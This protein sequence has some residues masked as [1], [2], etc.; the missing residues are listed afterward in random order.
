MGFASSLLPFAFLLLIFIIFVI[1][2]FF[3]RKRK[4]EYYRDKERPYKS[5]P[6]EDALSGR[7][8]ELL[9][10]FQT[11]SK[12]L[13]AQTE[14]RIRILNAL[15]AEADSK[16]QQMRGII[17]NEDTDRPPGDERPF[18]ESAP[19][20]RPVSPPK[21]K[22][23]PLTSTARE[24]LRRQFSEL[25][26]VYRDIYALADSGMTAIEIADDVGMK[27]GEIE[28]ILQLRERTQNL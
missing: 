11:M 18:A 4:I 22:E 7:F 21:P 15:I 20:A 14:T 3:R 17:G 23:T 6:E 16:I 25:D 28:L 13:T 27:R 9:V 5:L 10:E 12:E 2:P 24:E 8:E 26:N 1:P 19:T